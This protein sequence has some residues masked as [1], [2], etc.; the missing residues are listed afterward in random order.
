MYPHGLHH[1]CRQRG[2]VWTLLVCVCVCRWA[3]VRR[4]SE[5][6]LFQWLPH[7]IFPSIVPVSEG[8]LILHVASCLFQMTIHVPQGLWAF[9]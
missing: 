2:L 3:R 9:P 5:H 1:T 4:K 8:I 6:G 7:W